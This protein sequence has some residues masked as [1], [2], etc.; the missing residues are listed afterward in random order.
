MAVSISR[1]HSIFQLK[2]KVQEISNE[3]KTNFGFSYFQYLRCYNDGSAGLLLNDTNLTEYF[4][5]QP[6]NIPLIYSSFREEH[7]TRHS[8]WFLWDE[9]LPEYPVNLARN[10][11][12]ICNGLTLVRRS[13]DY[14]DMIAV[15]MPS[16]LANAGSFYLNKL[17]A[18]EQFII[19]FD[20]NEKELISNMH[21]D[22]IH[23]PDPHRDKNYQK[24]CLNSRHLEIQSKHGITY[25]TSQEL[26][27][28]RLLCSGLSYKET[29]HILD[30]SP[31]SVETY[32]SRAKIRTDLT[33]PEIKHIIANNCQ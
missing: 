30:I 14:Y 15:A 1:N 7:E 17:P 24:I 19:K 26:A 27:C 31:R 9:E 13:R 6:T 28:I 3:L 32:L 16:N 23:L 20:K 25:I 33:L 12:N 5:N 18:I 4:W 8:Y 10:Q 29:A 22:R 2:D 21:K 11:F